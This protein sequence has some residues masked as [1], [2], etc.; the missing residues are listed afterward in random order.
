MKNVPQHEAFG[1]L[2]NKLYIVSNGELLSINPSQINA[3]W[4]K[5]GKAMHIKSIAGY[6]N[7]LYGI[8]NG[9]RLLKTSDSG[10]IKWEK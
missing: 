3:Q 7:N 6:K 8:D 5:W 2:H 4:M 9:G 10:I 1:A